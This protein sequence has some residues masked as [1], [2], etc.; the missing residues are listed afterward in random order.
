MA[1]PSINGWKDLP[2]DLMVIELTYLDPKSMLVTGLVCRAWH[3]GDKRIRRVRSAARKLLTKLPFAMITGAP[4]PP[5]RLSFLAEVSLS[6]DQAVTLAL[7]V[8]NRTLN[9]AEENRLSHQ[10]FS[11]L[12]C[13]NIFIT[14]A[15]ELTRSIHSENVLSVLIPDM[16]ILSQRTFLDLN[17][18]AQVEEKE[19][20]PEASSA[21]S[22]IQIELVENEPAAPPASKPSRCLIC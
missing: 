19:V 7:S 11:R 20:V 21:P 17:E 4:P 18:F 6:G 13:N 2:N 14:H 10:D 12:L 15:P 22:P 8:Y 16:A 5:R 1:I 9:R 3:I